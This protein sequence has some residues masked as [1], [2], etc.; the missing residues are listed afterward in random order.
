MA[1]NMDNKSDGITWISP[2]RLIQLRHDAGKLP[3]HSSKI[4]ARQGGAYM[5]S[6]KGRGME[7]DLSL[8]H[9]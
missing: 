6:F 4:H 1:L 7:F 9:I 2:Q 8:I 3:L 5:S